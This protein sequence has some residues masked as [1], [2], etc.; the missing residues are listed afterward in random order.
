MQKITGWTAWPSA[1]PNES[2]KKPNLLPSY[3]FGGKY[4]K[5]SQFTRKRIRNLNKT[6]K[7]R[8]HK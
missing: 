3:L 6:H 7:Y 8:K 1:E 4:T 2:P 5:Y